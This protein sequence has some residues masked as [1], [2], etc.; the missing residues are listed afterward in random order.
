MFA[1]RPAEDFFRSGTNEEYG[2]KEQ[3][4]TEVA[5]LYNES[6]RKKKQCAEKIVEKK[7]ADDQQRELAVTLRDGAMRT[8]VQKRS[9]CK[10]NKKM[11]ATLTLPFCV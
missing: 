4:L 10:R 6:M 2:E 11:Y 9:K 8:L 5:Q 7:S 1:F 3:L